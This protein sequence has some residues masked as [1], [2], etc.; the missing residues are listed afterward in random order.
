MASAP[1][2]YDAIL[3]DIQM[4]VMN[5]YEAARAIRACVHP[6]AESIPVIAMTANVFAEDVFAAK[7]AGIDAHIGKPIDIGHLM[8][9]LQRCILK[10]IH[11]FSF[12]HS[13]KDDV[14]LQADKEQNDKTDLEQTIY[15]TVRK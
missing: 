6:Q 4:P 8:E 2:Y 15:G 12:G 11:N 5:G 9:V 10:V 1:R 14:P 7:A 13:V 3:M